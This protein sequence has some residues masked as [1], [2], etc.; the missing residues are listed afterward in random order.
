M[1]IQNTVR[2]TYDTEI[3][4]QLGEIHITTTDCAVVLPCTE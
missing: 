4:S 1:V 2:G 3:Q